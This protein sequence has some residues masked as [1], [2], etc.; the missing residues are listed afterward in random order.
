MKVDHSLQM[1]QTNK[2]NKSDFKDSKHKRQVLGPL[3]AEPVE[4]GRAERE[5]DLNG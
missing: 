2:A 5:R 1:E 3:P 4:C